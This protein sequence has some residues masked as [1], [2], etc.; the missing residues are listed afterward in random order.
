MTTPEKRIVDASNFDTD[1]QCLCPHC[2]DQ[3]LH[4]VSWENKVGRLVTQNQFAYSLL[5]LCCEGCGRMSSLDAEFS[6]G[7]IF[8]ALEKVTLRR[9]KE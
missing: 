6:K 4:T 9:E 2:G 1:A 8:L 7:R 3:H 5:L